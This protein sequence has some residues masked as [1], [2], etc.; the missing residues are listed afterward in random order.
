MPKEK[1]AIPGSILRFLYY[2]LSAVCFFFI[3][4]LAITVSP[5]RLDASLVLSMIIGVLLLTFMLH[6][7]QLLGAMYRFM[8]IKAEL[9]E[10]S[11]KLLSEK[12]KPEKQVTS[13]TES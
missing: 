1:I 9:L 2:L 5:D 7:N 4:L 8:V 6:V 3:F 12:N 13:E 11:Y 10:A